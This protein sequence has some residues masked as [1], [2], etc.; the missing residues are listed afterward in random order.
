MAIDFLFAASG[1]AGQCCSWAADEWLVAHLF[2]AQPRISGEWPELVRDV[3]AADII[4][5][6]E[7]G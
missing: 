1:A 5:F 4:A 6:L 7:H 2:A 3:K